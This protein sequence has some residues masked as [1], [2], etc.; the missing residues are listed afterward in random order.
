M[1]GDIQHHAR[2][3]QLATRDQHGRTRTRSPPHCRSLK[4][5]YQSQASGVFDSGSQGRRTSLAQ[6][7]LAW[8]RP[9]IANTNSLRLRLR[10]LEFEH[11]TSSVIARIA[12]DTRPTFDIVFQARRIQTADPSLRE[13]VPKTDVRRPARHDPAIVIVWRVTHSTHSTHTAQGFASHRLGRRSSEF[14]ALPVLAYMTRYRKR[15]RRSPAALSSIVHKTNRAG[16]RL[17][18][19]APGGGKV[20]WSLHRDHVRE[21]ARR[22]RRHRGFAHAQSG[23]YTV[24]VVV[25]ACAERPHCEDGWD[26]MGPKK[27][28][29]APASR[30][31][32][33]DVCLAKYTFLCGAEDEEPVWKKAPSGVCNGLGESSTSTSMHA[34]YLQLLVYLV[35]GMDLRRSRAFGHESVNSLEVAGRT[36][37]YYS[38]YSCKRALAMAAPSA[39][40][41]LVSSL[42]K[43]SDGVVVLREVRMYTILM[44]EIVH[45]MAHDLVEGSGTWRVGRAGLEGGSSPIGTE[46]DVRAVANLNHVVD[47]NNGA[48][49]ARQMGTLVTALNAR[50]QT[51]DWGRAT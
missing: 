35:L 21:A 43:R 42:E 38:W 15:R 10:R 1:D 6:P 8:S 39:N 41:G 36:S 50:L 12:A 29:S 47:A 44:Y 17:R 28:E 13:G 24:N 5:Y 37:E 26:R 51:G 7:S 49:G 31:G 3:S 32:K 4:S 9:R 16:V 14:G 34:L 45:E 25:L 22:R 11:K 46:G 23:A 20:G 2:N 48:H 40:A 33:A 30:Q 18:A 19:W 27:K